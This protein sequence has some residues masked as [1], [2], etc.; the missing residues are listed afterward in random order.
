MAKNGRKQIFEIIIYDNSP[1]IKQMQSYVSPVT[2]M[3]RR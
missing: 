3:K 2:F 1:E